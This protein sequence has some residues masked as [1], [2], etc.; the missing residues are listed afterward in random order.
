MI[1]FNQKSWLKPYID[2]NTDLTKQAK[3]DF[4]KDYF[5]LVNNT[6]FEKIMKNLSKHMDLLTKDKRR[7]SLV[8]EP[9]YHT[10][11]IF[12]ET[13]FTIE[14]R[15]TQQLKN[16]PFY[17]RLSILELIKTAMYKFCYDYVKPKYSGKA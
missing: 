5:K 3:N 7:N 10:K 4:E 6:V 8:S 12:T 9:N 17:L 1:E 13:L 15:K 11:N 16:K 14:R 2:I